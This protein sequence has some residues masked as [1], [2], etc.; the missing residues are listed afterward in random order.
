MR[1]D[2]LERYQIRRELGRGGMGVVYEAY[3]AQSRAVVALKTIESTFA[4]SLY[5]LKHEFRALSDIHHPNLVRF[6]ELACEHGQWFFTM[7]LVRGTDFI[8]Y[9]R[10]SEKVN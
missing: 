2:A 5:R 4:E 3:D 1:A 6:G 9:V 10:V 7:E 8:D